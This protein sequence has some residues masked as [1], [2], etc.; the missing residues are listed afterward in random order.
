VNAFTSNV[1]LVSCVTVSSGILGVA[2]AAIEGNTMCDIGKAIEIIQ[3]A[4]LNLPA[5]LPTPSP[6]RESDPEPV[7]PLLVPV[8]VEMEDYCPSQRQSFESLITSTPMVGHRVWIWDLEVEQVQ[9]LNG[10]VW[11][12]KSAF[13]ATCLENE[14]LKAIYPELKDKQH[15]VPAINCRCGM[16]ASIKMQH[17]IDIKYAAR[18]HPRGC[19]PVG[20]AR[21]L[22]PRL[23]CAICVPKELYRSTRDGRVLNGDR[24]RIFSR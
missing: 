5:P 23:A 14:D 24:K 9:S 13:E 16:Y 1:T 20:T 15:K 22:Y 11:T 19:V 18:Q 21:A 8:P 10:A 12:P 4:P 6:D 2:W 17:L 3:V 7:A